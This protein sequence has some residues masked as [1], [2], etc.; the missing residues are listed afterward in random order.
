MSSDLLVVLITAPDEAA[1]VK[2]AHAV[3]GPG[4]AACVNVVPAVRSIY[5]WEGKLEDSSE[6][7]LIVKTTAERFA[8]LERAVIAVHPYSVP[9]VI[10]LPVT[11]AFQAYGTW[12]AE[13]CR[14]K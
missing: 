6:L 2:I 13:Q 5:Q 3:V 14:K 10:A 1:A 11:A 12:V 4:L 9:E 8:E 7:L